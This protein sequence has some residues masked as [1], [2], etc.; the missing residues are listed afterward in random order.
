MIPT[1]KK[2]RHYMTRGGVWVILA[3]YNEMQSIIYRLKE[4]EQITVSAMEVETVED[5][6]K[7]RFLIEAFNLWTMDEIKEFIK[8]HKDF[9]KIEL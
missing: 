4:E 7:A 6:I 9:P 2:L 8:S 5:A 3:N 1:F